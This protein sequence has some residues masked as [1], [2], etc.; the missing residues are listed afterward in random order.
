MPRKKEYQTPKERYCAYAERQRA[1]G[2]VVKSVALS[3]QEQAEV[4]EIR[5]SL[6][7]PSD[8]AAIRAAI[9]HYAEFLGV[10]PC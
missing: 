8:V 2:V 1:A 7:L 5:K 9:R 4:T 6:A 10:K 3:V